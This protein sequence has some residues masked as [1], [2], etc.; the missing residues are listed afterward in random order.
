MR[1]LRDTALL[2]PKN[3]C[4]GFGQLSH[5]FVPVSIWV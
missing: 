5:E 3:S 1:V 4:R 2:C